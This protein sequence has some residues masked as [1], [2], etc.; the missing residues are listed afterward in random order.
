MF[1]NNG[2]KSAKWNH[3]LHEDHLH[4]PCMNL[5]LG[6]WTKVGG[7]DHAKVCWWALTMPRCADG[8]WQEQEWERAG[9]R[10]F[11]DMVTTCVSPDPCNARFAC[12]AAEVWAIHN[13]PSDHPLD[14]VWTATNSR[15]VQLPPT[16]S[17]GVILSWKFPLF[18]ESPK[19]K[20]K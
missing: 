14:M 17:L 2:T 4:V 13:R 18:S 7:T 15:A 20:K 16:L 10:G 19:E 1:S 8:R 5:K 11:T 6:V 3:M 12:V 9:E